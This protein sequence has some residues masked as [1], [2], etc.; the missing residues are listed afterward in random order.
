M[1]YKEI[2]PFTHRDTSG[3]KPFQSI[4]FSYLRCQLHIAIIKYAFNEIERKKCKQRFILNGCHS[5]WV[6]VFFSFSTPTEDFERNWCVQDSQIHAQFAHIVLCG[7]RTIHGKIHCSL[8]VSMLPSHV[9]Y[10]TSLWRQLRFA[11]VFFFHIFFF[12]FIFQ[13]IHKQHK[14]I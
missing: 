3:V 12:L 2:V 13:I 7:G 14:Y 6:W 10:F 9:L 11:F 1:R 5:C 4:Y 8:F